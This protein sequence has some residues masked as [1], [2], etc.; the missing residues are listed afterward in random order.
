MD[1]L[2]GNIMLLSAPWLAEADVRMVVGRHEVF[3]ARGE[4]ALHGSAGTLVSLVPVTDEVR[5]VRTE[6]LRYPLTREKLVRSSTRCIS[7]EMTGA[8]ARVTHDE[9]ELL[10][11]VY[12]GRLR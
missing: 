12:R 8:L 4:V 7:N 5:G 10:V 9:G 2:L 6:G 3:L 11:V 1:H